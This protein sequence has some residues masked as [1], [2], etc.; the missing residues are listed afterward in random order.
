M[1]C[2]VC[3]VLFSGP[4]LR[5]WFHSLHLAPPPPFVRDRR[6][7]SFGTAPALRSGPPPP[8]AVPFVWHRRRLPS[9]GPV[10]GPRRQH[11]NRNSKNKPEIVP[12]HPIGRMR[13]QIGRKTYQI[14]LNFGPKSRLA[15]LRLIYRN[16]ASTL[17]NQAVLQN[18]F[19]AGTEKHPEATGT[20]ALR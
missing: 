1:L 3:H 8:A 11:F 20:R 5:F 6:R 13:Q 17:G 9:F 16:V 12:R 14:G 4:R 2:V 10:A 15:K 18:G 7:P 19:K